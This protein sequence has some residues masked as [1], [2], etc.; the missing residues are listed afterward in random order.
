MERMKECTSFEQFEHMM[1]A[2]ISY[3]EEEA[4]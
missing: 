1:C 3:Q 2:S 4:A